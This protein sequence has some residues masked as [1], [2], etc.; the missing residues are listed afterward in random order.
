M[1]DKETL[2]AYEKYKEAHKEPDALTEHEFFIEADLY[3]FPQIWGS[4]ALGFGGIGGQM[5][6][7]A[8]T[9]V[10]LVDV[11]YRFAAIFFDGKLAYTVN[12]FSNAFFTDLKEFSMAPVYL[13]AKYRRDDDK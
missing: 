10:V 2:L 8:Q 5:M 4:T 6:T 7:K 1:R 13:R 3:S 9:D 11:P 12:N